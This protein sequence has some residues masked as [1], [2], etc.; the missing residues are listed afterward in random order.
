MNST[1]TQTDGDEVWLREALQRYATY[2]DKAV[3]DEIAEHTS[4]LATRGARRF[5]D[6]GEFMSH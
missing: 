6:C 3:R 4:W 2:R 1:Q 5:A